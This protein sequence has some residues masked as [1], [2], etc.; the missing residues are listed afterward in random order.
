MYWTANAVPKFLVACNWRPSLLSA[1]GQ[2]APVYY[3][4]VSVFRN[5]VTLETNRSRKVNRRFSIPKKR[6]GTQ[7]SRQRADWKTSR[8]V[9]RDRPPAFLLPRAI[10]HRGVHRSIAEQQAREHPADAPPDFYTHQ[11]L[12]VLGNHD[13]FVPPSRRVSNLVRRT[14]P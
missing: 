9:G 4:S 8:Q 12:V 14:E 6:E 1:P 5:L 13:L 11:K 10:A 2:L 7:I 3:Q